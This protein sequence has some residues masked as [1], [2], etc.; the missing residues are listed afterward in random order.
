MNIPFHTLV[1]FT[2]DILGM[3]VS[4]GMMFLLLWQAPHHRD[5]RLAAIYMAAQ[6]CWCFSNLIENTSGLFHG[7]VI[8]QFIHASLLIMGIHCLAIFTLAV[9][10]TGLWPKLAAR[11]VVAAF[12][13]YIIGSAIP[14]MQGKFVLSLPA[15]SDRFHNVGI[16][17]AGWIGFSILLVFYIASFILFR[18]SDV[19]PG[20]K[21][22]TAITTL[23]FVTIGIPPLM[24]W[25]TDILANSVSA[26]FFAYA[27]IREKLFNPLE[28]MNRTLAATNDQLLTLTKELRE[29]EARLAALLEN[30]PDAILAADLD[31]RLIISNAPAR[32]LFRRRL[33][34]DLVTGMNPFDYLP[35]DLI[36]LFRDY[37]NRM[38]KG[39][40]FT[41][42][43]VMKIP[44]KPRDVEVSGFPI[45]MP[46]NKIVGVCCFIRDVT[47]SRLAEKELMVA[48]ERAES[49][50]QAK[51]NF[52]A[53][54]SHEL[55]TPL[56]SIMA[57]AM[58][59]CDQN[60]PL[61]ATLKQEVRDCAKRIYDS[62]IHLKGLIEGIL[63]FSRIE[64]GRLDL[65]FEAIEL[66]SFADFMKSQGD[67]L[68][69]TY[70]IHFVFEPP[71]SG[72]QWV[73]DL[74]ILRQVVINLMANAF[75]FTTEGEVRVSLT[76]EGPVLRIAVCDTGI[77]ISANELE[78]VFEPFYQVSTGSTRRYGGA[79]LGLSIVRRLVQEL[80]GEV[81]VWSKTGE[82]TCFTIRLPDRKMTTDPLPGTT[83]PA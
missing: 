21:W 12:A 32:D 79:G 50:N 10:A 56:T 57:H 52:L 39:E 37:Y 23:G 83:K 64:A 31:Q 62:A 65:S 25:P 69:S 28:E 5:N 75:K 33:D 29:S 8:E 11:G 30:T 53:M 47:A 26:C 73:C 4:L 17:T 13:G 81:T 58:L 7:R 2:I 1:T 66:D 19:H 82:G 63:Q 74:Q 46:D 59:M 6:V 78:K 20:M 35:P 44:D 43:H 22:G 77:G 42:N 45:K 54:V 48:K 55:R 68:A 38:L 61:G 80:G 41:A 72:R 67:T 36:S 15:G 16:L 76:L 3:A 24:N 49:G 40:S 18:R 9:H 70:G 51:S 27:I 71:P 14:V 34:L 60:G